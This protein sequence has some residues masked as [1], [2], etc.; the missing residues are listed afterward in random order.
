MGRAL[1]PGYRFPI[2]LDYDM[3][4]PEECRPTIFIA[5]LPMRKQQQLADVWDSAP[6]TTSKEFFDYV[7]EKLSSV[8]VDWKNYINPHTGNEIP[9]SKEA[10]QEWITFGEARELFRKILASGSLSKDDEKN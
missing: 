7:E 3:E 9:Y 6:K 5:A 4:K 1:E 8:I 2:Y 10:I